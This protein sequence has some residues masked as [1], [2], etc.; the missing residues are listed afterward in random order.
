MII[1]ATIREIQVIPLEETIGATMSALIISAD[2][3]K[4]NLEVMALVIHLTYFLVIPEKIT[5][6]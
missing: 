5:I 1:I 6:R 2:I 4:T 3:T